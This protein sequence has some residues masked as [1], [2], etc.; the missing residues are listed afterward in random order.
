M[1]Y[2]AV[3]WPAAL[4]SPLPP[5]LAVSEHVPPLSKRI[6]VPPTRLHAPLAV[7]V[8]A[9]LDVAETETTRWASPKVAAGNVPNAIDWL[10]LATL[11]VRSWGGAARYPGDAPRVNV[12]VHVP[13]EIHSIMVE[14]LDWRRQTPAGDTDRETK[15]PGAVA[16][17]S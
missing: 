5:W 6:V 11:N 4:Y 14:L 17:G 10:A 9:R 8:I 7:S 13:T 1:V 15:P 12:T 16:T 3:A 2:V